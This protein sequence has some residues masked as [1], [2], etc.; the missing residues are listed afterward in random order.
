MIYGDGRARHELEHLLRTEGKGLPI[1]LKGNVDSED[2]QEHLLNA[3]TITL[4]SDYEGLPIAFMEAMACGVVPICTNMP[5]GIPELVRHGVTGLIVPNRES[6]F[7]DAVRRLRFEPQL[8]SSLS[9]AARAHVE[10]EYSIDVCARRWIDLMHDLGKDSR[11]HKRIVPS[12]KL[13]IPPTHEEFVHQEI[14]LWPFKLSYALRLAEL[15]TPPFAINLYKTMK[16]T[17][18]LFFKTMSPKLKSK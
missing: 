16:R 14:R 2:I 11:D 10:T 17:L 8:W 1:F 18:G 5:S 13:D 4:L 15:Y 6:G 3:H 7:V 9:R 12:E